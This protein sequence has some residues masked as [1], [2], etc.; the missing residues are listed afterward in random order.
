[1]RWL[2]SR[3]RERD[4]IDREIQSYLIHEIDDNLARGF[5]AEQAR[6]AAQE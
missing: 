6:R 3:R 5:T 2:R 1:M 4:E